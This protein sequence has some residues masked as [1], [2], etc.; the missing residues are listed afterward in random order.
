MAAPR[1]ALGNVNRPTLLQ[2]VLKGN[3]E[4]NRP[5]SGAPILT[6]PFVSQPPPCFRTPP[7]RD[8]AKPGSSSNDRISKACT[9]IEHGFNLPRLRSWFTCAN[10]G[11]PA[12]LFATS[13]AMEATWSRK[14]VNGQFGVSRISPRKASWYEAFVSTSVANILGNPGARRFLKQIPHF[15]GLLARAEFWGPWRFCRWLERCLS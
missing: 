3:Q 9:R 1:R 10:A 11:Y 13:Q 7:I 8:T 6:H 15:G 14:I 5:C 2:A 4:E 12:S